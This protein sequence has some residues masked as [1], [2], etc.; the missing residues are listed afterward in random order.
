MEFHH[1]AAVLPL[2]DEEDLQK[3]AD[4]I[5]AN[6]LRVP[7]VLFDGKILDGRNR[8]RACVTAKVDPRFEPFKGDDMAALA[9]VASLNVR[10]RHLEPSQ[11]AAV[12]AL[13]APLYEEAA[14]KREK[15]GK[16]LD[17]TARVREGGTAAARAAKAL[18]V[19][20]RSV[21]AAIAV[22]KKGATEVFE[23]LRTGN[24]SVKAAE[25][26]A[27][28]P[29]SEQRAAVEAGPK[30]AAQVAK[31]VVANERRDR[32]L[33]KIEKISRGNAQLETP[34]K[35]PVIYA[36]PPWRYGHAISVSREIENQY[37]TMSLEEICAL[38]V[39]ELSSE[40][41]VLFMWATSPKLAESMRVIEAWGFEYK[42]CAVWDKEKI[43]MGYYF[44]QQHE[45]LLVAT[46]GAIPA[47]PVEQRF[48][49]VFR[50]ERPELHS[51]KPSHFAELIERFYPKLP[52]IELFCRAPRKGWSVWGNQAA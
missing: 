25:Q 36:D 24:V 7:I 39:S 41:A 3:L 46:R 5:K 10:R 1:Y 52:K 11:V 17:P 19:S 37:P 23:A 34:I 33:E 30:R 18:G 44:R 38:N 35:Y 45:L 28:L 47:P 12:G 40:D 21:E 2:L 20:E 43:G 8:Y 50:F 13:M 48:G 14:R 26:L 15:A 27:K 32:R 49:S 42:T 4:D 16:K 51:Q 9:L 31:Q 22:K 29:K 6:G